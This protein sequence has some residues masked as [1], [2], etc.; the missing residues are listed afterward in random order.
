MSVVAVSCNGDNL[1]ADAPALLWNVILADFLSSN[2]SCE[3]S[4]EGKFLEEH[5]VGWGVVVD[6]SVGVC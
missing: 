4:D 5:R 3:G 2:G 1:G 6:L